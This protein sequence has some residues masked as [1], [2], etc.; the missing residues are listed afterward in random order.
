MRVADAASHR[1]HVFAVDE[2]RDAEGFDDLLDEDGDEVRR[3]LLILE[4]TRKVA[5]NTGELGEAKDFSVRNVG[6][7]D[8]HQDWEEMMFA[9]TDFLDAFDN[10]H[11]VANRRLTFGF[12]HLGELVGFGAGTFGHFKQGFGG[13]H[14]CLFGAF[15]VKVHTEFLQ[16]ARV[17]P[18]D[19][20]NV[21]NG[22][23]SKA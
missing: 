11:I 19:C 23:T 2:D 13:A 20:V 21:W 4:A 16:D 5:G 7:G 17:V 15:G 18:R 14:G 1:A 10:D 3:A 8:V 6:D 12:E 9:Q 22:H